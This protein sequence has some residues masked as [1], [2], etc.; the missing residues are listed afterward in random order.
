MADKITDLREVLK[1]AHAYF[2]LLKG[3]ETLRL[4]LWEIKEDS[5]IIE[6][7]K[8][9]RMHKT[10]LGLIPTIEG[11]AVY[12]I[13]G[14]VDNEELPEEMPDTMRLRVDP[15][16]V[17][18]VNRRVYPRISFTP[19]IEAVIVVEG[20]DRTVAATIINLSA[21]GLRIETLDELPPDK[22]LTFKFEIECDDEIH[23]L[24]PA[25]TVVYELPSNAGHSYGVKFLGEEK[26]F[27]KDEEADIE[28]IERTV[29]MM[30]LVNKLLVRQ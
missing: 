13:E 10:M 14:A 24:S 3:S 28:S 16:K 22:K 23:V 21:G 4:R 20:S 15:S 2:F 6:M 26:A 27:L 19:P 5:I 25:G 7:P 30:T 29:D 17:K 12:E 8:S 18:R 9:A 1:E 11:S